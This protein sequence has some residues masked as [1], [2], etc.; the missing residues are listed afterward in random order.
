MIAGSA[1]WI[2]ALALA[3]CGPNKSDGA[4]AGQE[5]GPRLDNA[6]APGLVCFSN[7]CIAPDEPAVPRAS[8][9]PSSAP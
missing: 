5:T 1:R 6:C 4:T 8:P 3:A 7:L 9:G 2:L